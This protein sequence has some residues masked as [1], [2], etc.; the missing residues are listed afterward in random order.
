MKMVLSVLATIAALYV[1]FV[2]FLYFTQDKLVYFPPATAQI[3]TKPLEGFT[4]Q[5]VTTKDGLD[6]QGYYLAPK[7]GMPLLVEFH[8]NASHPAWEASKFTKLVAQGYGLLLAEYRGYG[9]NEGKP[10]ERNLYLDGE[11]YLN[12]VR[13][14]PDLVGSPIVVY[15]SSLGSGVAVNVAQ[16]YPEISALILETPFSKLSAVGAFHYPYIPFAQ[17][18]MKNKYDS[19]KK[20][21]DIKVPTLFLLAKN[22]AIV[23]IQF[24]QALVDAANEPKVVHVFDEAD[25]INIYKFGAEDVVQQFLK[26]HIQ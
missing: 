22:D 6:I 14:N 5:T 16:E 18:I 23:P 26:E 17:Y 10:N 9:G 8:G 2:L 4:R 13:K 20:I 15:G 24:G 12:W 19:A 21:K 7:P 25:H 1:L 3:D 11:A